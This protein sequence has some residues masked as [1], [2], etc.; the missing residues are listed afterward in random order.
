MFMADQDLILL[1][2]DRDDDILLIRNAFAKGALSNPLQI[3]RDGEEA[4]AYLSGV[5]RYNNRAEFPL[6][7]LMLLDLKMPGLDGFDVLRWVRSQPGLSA[8]R[9]VVLTS[10]DSIEDVNLAYQL[11][12][13]SFMVKPMDFEDVVA[14]T[15]FIKSYWIDLSKSPQSFRAAR[16]RPP[17]NQ[18]PKAGEIDRDGPDAPTE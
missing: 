14:T 3:V 2:E 12:A 1:A 5:G 9:I 18:N 10:S 8:L 17:A 15:Q 6:P 7:S 16:R 13:N 4:I 11:G